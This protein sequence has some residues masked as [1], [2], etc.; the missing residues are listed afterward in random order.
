MHNDRRN[1]QFYNIQIEQNAENELEARY[2]KNCA[3]SILCMEKYFVY[4]R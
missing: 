2:I 4:L 3:K 1:A